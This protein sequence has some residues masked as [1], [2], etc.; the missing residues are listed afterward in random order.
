M[1]KWGDIMVYLN[2]QLLKTNI[3]KY[4][5]ITNCLMKFYDNYYIFRKEGR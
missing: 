2:R 4:Y 5:R 1:G 3:I